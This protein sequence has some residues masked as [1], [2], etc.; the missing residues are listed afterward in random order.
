MEQE[1][2]AEGRRIRRT[3]QKIS[4]KYEWRHRLLP[5]IPS[6]LF[7]QRREALGPM[8]VTKHPVYS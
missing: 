8:A 2:K 1:L 3:S 5:L 6:N 7:S 4:Q